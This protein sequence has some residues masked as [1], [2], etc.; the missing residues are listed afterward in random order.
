[1]NTGAAAGI[2]GLVGGAIG[3]RIDGNRGAV[4]G[5]LGGAAL[6]AV[7]AES[8]NASQAQRREAERLA[9]VYSRKPATV[10]TTKARKTKYIAVPVKSEKK[11]KGKDV[12]LVNQETGKAESEAYVPKAGESFSTGEVVTVG[13]KEA[14]VGN[15]FQGI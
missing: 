2:G 6:G 3:H 9:A 15:S 12:V 14:V 11:S 5:A 13:G 7:F 10:K 8:Y 1:M 4:I